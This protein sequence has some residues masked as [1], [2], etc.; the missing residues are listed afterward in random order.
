MMFVAAI[1]NDDFV[2]QDH[3]NE[4]FCFL[5]YQ[6]NNKKTIKEIVCR[7]LGKKED[8]KKLVEDYNSRYSKVS[9]FEVN[10]VYSG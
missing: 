3:Q 4:Y 2:K 6:A 1:C 5:A 10:F 9:H 8:A 7:H